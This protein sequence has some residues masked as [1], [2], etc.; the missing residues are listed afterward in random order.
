MGDC[1]LMCLTGL[2]TI[3]INTPIQLISFT[4]MLLIPSVQFQRP[5]ESVPR[6]IEPVLMTSGLCCFFPLN[7]QLSVYIPT[8]LALYVG[9]N[10]KEIQHG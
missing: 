1:G 4:E 2:L 6:N 9:K 10:G 5:V 3:I 7:C 8:W